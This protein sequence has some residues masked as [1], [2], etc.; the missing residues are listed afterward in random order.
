VQARRSGNGANNVKRRWARD[1]RLMIGDQSPHYAGHG[2]AVC[3]S[4]S[5]KAF[6]FRLREP[7]VQL[8]FALSSRARRTFGSVHGNVE[9]GGG[10]NVHVVE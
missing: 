2:F 10:A 7:Y 1:P 3:R 9:D 6:V 5:L 8:M 4:L